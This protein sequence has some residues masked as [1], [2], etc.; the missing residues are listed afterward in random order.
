[1]I[2]KYALKLLSLVMIQLYAIVMLITEWLY[3]TAYVH[4]VVTVLF[5]QT[6]SV[7][8]KPFV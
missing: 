3:K 2:K 7:L 6:T 4:L 5:N 1:M 8:N